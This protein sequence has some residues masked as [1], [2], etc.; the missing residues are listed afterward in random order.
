MR[1]GSLIQKSNELISEIM[2][3]DLSLS[4]SETTVEINFALIKLRHTIK[5][6]K[7]DQKGIQN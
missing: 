4:E 6:K 5:K 2:D 7:E 1:K 3:S